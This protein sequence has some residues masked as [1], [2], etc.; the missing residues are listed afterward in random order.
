MKDFQHW[1]KIFFVLA[2]GIVSTKTDHM[3][4]HVPPI[5]FENWEPIAHNDVLH[6]LASFD[7]TYSMAVRYRNVKP[8]KEQFVIRE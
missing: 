5:R 1:V 6:Y 3:A 8:T 7:F 4:F 2:N